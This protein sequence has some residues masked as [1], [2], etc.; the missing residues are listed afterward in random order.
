MSFD[1]RFANQT[2]MIEDKIKVSLYQ[3]LHEASKKT[4]WIR[5]TGLGV[6]I[7]SGFLTIAAH[8]ASIVECVFKGLMNIFG[9]CYFE[10][11][12]ITKGLSQLFIQAP[13]GIASIPGYVF[14]SALGVIGQTVLVA[15]I[16]V[17][18]TKL[19]LDKHERM[20]KDVNN[21]QEY[22]QKQLEDYQK[23]KADLIKNYEDLKNLLSGKEN[24]E[25]VQQG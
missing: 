7:V 20:I 22:N 8:I 12:K 5:L 4:R 23:R 19:S 14:I 11:C 3:K 1:V 2:L 10:R 21:P 16:P 18:Y 25:I 17:Q 13:L 15:C 6:G 9:A 24:K